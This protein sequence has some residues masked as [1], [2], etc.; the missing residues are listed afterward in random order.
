MKQN[1][2]RTKRT[3]N[4]R[5]AGC[6]D[7]NEK[8]A[9][10]RFLDVRWVSWRFDVLGLAVEAPDGVRTTI[11]VSRWDLEQAL[12]KLGRDLRG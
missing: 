3:W 2:P 10:T 7:P 11:H 5:I 9:R 4:Y 12:K 6:R 1:S 8:P